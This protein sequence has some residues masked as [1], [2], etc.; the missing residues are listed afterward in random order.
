M[1]GANMKIARHFVL[2]KCR[3]VILKRAVRLSGTIICYEISLFRFLDNHVSRSYKVYNVKH[4]VLVC[5]RFHARYC[6]TLR[7]LMRI[8]CG[9]F[10]VTISNC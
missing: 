1:H 8:K 5:I 2:C 10:E 4:V 9:V 7:T 3:P 6:S